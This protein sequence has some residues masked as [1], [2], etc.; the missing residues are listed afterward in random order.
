ML[1]L[2]LRTALVRICRETYS[3]AIALRKLPLALND[4]ETI[5]GKLYLDEK[6]LNAGFL[7]PPTV[8]FTSPEW[9]EFNWDLVP[10][11]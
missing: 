10:G 2:W 6:C 11:G 4:C 8:A 7:N 1:W 5:W 3:V 9:G